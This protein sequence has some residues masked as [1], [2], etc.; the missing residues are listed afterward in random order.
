VGFVRNHWTICVGINVRMCTPEMMFMRRRLE[1]NL[2]KKKSG[3]N[4]KI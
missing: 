2:Q 1:K 3:M 4:K